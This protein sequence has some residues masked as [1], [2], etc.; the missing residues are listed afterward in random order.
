MS[1]TN[2]ECP[3]SQ[4]ENKHYL[5]VISPNTGNRICRNSKCYFV[6]KYSDGSGAW[7]MGFDPTTAKSFIK[8]T[9]EQTEVVKID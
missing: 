8:E 5:F 6:V 9:A 7:E 4:P 2:E 3:G 1:Q